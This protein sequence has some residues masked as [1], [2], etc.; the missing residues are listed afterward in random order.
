MVLYRD[1]MPYGFCKIIT[2]NGDIGMGNFIYD[3][4]RHGWTIFYCGDRIEVGWY[5]K[6]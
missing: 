1:K 4:L 6:S 5:K 2:E 3:G